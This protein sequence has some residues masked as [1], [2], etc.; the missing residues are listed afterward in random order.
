M[1]LFPYVYGLWMWLFGFSWYAARLLSALLAVGTGLL[2]YQY[3]V[4]LTSKRHLGLLAVGLYADGV[5]AFGKA[6]ELT[7]VSVY[8][9]AQALGRRGIVRHYD[10][11]ELARD[12]DYAGGQ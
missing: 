11:D 8:E 4:R 3:V 12:I 10:E 2:L 5:L 1:P 9:F 6:R 7:G